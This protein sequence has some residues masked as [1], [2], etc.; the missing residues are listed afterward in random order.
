[1]NPKYIKKHIILDTNILISMKQDLHCCDEIVEVL[2]KEDLFITLFS[3]YELFNNNSKNLDYVISKMSLI[4][5]SFDKRLIGT[6]EIIEGLAYYENS[7]KKP[8][9][10]YEIKTMVEEML[11]PLFCIFVYTY[12]YNFGLY[13]NVN[14]MN[15]FRNFIT[16]KEFIHYLR[17]AV[18]VIIKIDKN[19]KQKEVLYNFIFLNIKYLISKFGTYSERLRQWISETNDGSKL[20]NIYK[21]NNTNKS[22]RLSNEFNK[23]FQ[24]EIKGALV[25]HYNDEFAMYI[26]MLYDRCFNESMAIDIND[27]ID[28][29]IISAIGKDY[30]ICTDDSKVKKYAAS[31]GKLLDQNEDICLIKRKYDNIL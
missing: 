18:N 16:D 30:C 17:N 19:K 29:L 6:K 10:Y 9:I 21:A 26:K 23:Y 27:F 22:K 20:Y 4:N 28:G 24:G 15:E 8:M 25:K 1:M 2:S 7:G 31:I 12:I 11:K 3:I 14:R 13:I 5:N